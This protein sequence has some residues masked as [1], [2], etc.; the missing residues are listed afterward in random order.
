LIFQDGEVRQLIN[1]DGV[2]SQSSMNMG[3]AIETEY[4]Y[5]ELEN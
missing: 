2:T 4:W 5:R 3:N 1:A